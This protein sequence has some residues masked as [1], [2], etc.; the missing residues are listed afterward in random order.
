MKPAKRVV[1]T[2]LGAITPVGNDVKTTWESILLGK[3]GITTLEGFDVPGPD[4][5]QFKSRIGGRIK[6]FDPLTHFSKKDLKKYDPFL[7]YG[8]VAAEEAWADANITVTEDNARRI[9][10]AIGS[11]IGGIT[12]IEHQ[13]QMIDSTDSVKMSPYSIPKTII[14]M[15]S[16]HFS[17]QHNLRGPNTSVVT[18]C[19]TGTHNIGMAARMIA[20]GE[21][22]AMVAGGADKATTAIGL[23]GFAAARALSE[24]NDDPAGASRPWDKDRDGFV[25]SDGAGVIVL[26]SYDHAVAR[27]AHIYAELVGFGMNADAHHMT[28]PSGQGAVECMQLATEDAGIDPSQINYINAHGTS[29]GAGDVK[30][31]QAVEQLMG[32]SA[33]NVVMSSTKSMTGHTLGA[34]GAIEA[35]FTILAIEDQVAPPTIN[36]DNPDEGCNLDY[37][38]HESKTLNIEYALSNSFGFGGTN[39]SLIFKKLS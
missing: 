30:E 33:K 22:D 20:Y 23:G 12:A 25:L 17:I 39:G 36:L 38:A 37:A 11:G 19:T 32:A 27:G 21:A 14:N 18:A 7:Q 9:G 2:G 29:T 28:L 3:S 34:A 31:S 8:L 1:V 35:I 26:E 10:V 5:S 6:N 4:M 13:R 24:R 16:G 15:I